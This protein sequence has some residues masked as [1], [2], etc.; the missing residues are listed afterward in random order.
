MPNHFLGVTVLLGT[1]GPGQLPGAF[2]LAEDSATIMQ[3]SMSGEVPRLKL[4]VIIYWPR[5]N[6]W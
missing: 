4:V 6:L 2:P 3:E 1:S 5:V